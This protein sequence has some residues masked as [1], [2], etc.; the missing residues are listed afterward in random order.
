MYL[1]LKLCGYETYK[2][3]EV[4]E[5][6]RKETEEDEEMA[7]RE[8]EQEDPVP[9]VTHVNNIL[10]SIFPKVE[11]NINNQQFYN[12]KDLCAHKCHNF[13]NFKSA[14]FEY[15]GVL[16]CKEY[17]NEEIPDEIMEAPLSESFFFTRMKMLSRPD[18]FMLYGNWGSTFSPFLNGYIQ[19]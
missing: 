7:A 17:H 5:Q 15:N 19:I 3:K 1:A 18:G 14:F 10:H 9:L 6:H 2:T 8:E 4:K 11:V 16:H 13:N 12:S